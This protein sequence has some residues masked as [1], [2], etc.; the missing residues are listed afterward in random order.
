MIPFLA[1]LLCIA[2]CA[3]V[4][5]IVVAVELGIPAKRYRI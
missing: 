1:I 5:T 2:I 3:C 4:A